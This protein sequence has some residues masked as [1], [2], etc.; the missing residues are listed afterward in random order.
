MTAI[1]WVRQATPDDYEAILKIRDQVAVDLLQR[2]FRWNPNA[3]TRDHLEEWNQAGV[4][5]VGEVRGQVI[6][7]I[8]V[9]LHDP[10][11]WWSRAD[12]AGYV[13]D[14]MIDPSHR[15]QGVGAHLLR[16]AELYLQGLGRSRVRLDC[17]A[18]NDRLCRYYE[19]AGYQYVET[20]ESGFAQFEK[21][22]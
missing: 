2:G 21:R 6:A 15:H 3:L 8:A 13:R 7:C 9:W 1:P 14:L 19:A 16:W 18:G 11:G 22:L 4:L 20:D 12:L 5:W 10:I 17:D